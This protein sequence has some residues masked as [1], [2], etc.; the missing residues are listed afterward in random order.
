[1]CASLKHPLHI[2]LIP[3]ASCLGSPTSSKYKPIS[4][5]ETVRVG[6]AGSIYGMAI[7]APHIAATAKICLPI[8]YI[9]T[10]T[11]ASIGT[12]AIAFLD[13]QD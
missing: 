8:E 4:I 13:I 6:V 10:F 5:C 12:P 2:W 3:K 11:N 7:I 9:N 1:M